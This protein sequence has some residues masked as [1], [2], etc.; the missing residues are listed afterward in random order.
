MSKRVSIV[1]INYNQTRVTC[2]LLQSLRNLTYKDVEV[3]LVDNYS[4]EDPSLEITTSFPEVKYLRSEVNLGFAGGNNLG[5]KN[6][7]GD[8]IMFLN[9]DTE[10]DPSFLEPLVELFE[11]NPDAGLASSKILYFNSGG[12]IQYAG[13]T[14]INP[15][16]GRNKRIGFMEKDNGQYNTICETDLGH[17]AAMMVPRK[18]IEKIGVMPEFF[19]LYYEEVDWCE[20]IKRAGYKIY[21]VPQSQVYH[22]ESMSVGKNSTLKTYY[23]TRNRLLFMR[24]NTTGYVK[25]F[26]IVFFIMISLPKNTLQFIV[27]REINHGKAFWKAL[28]WNVTHLSNGRKMKLFVR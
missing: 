23:L 8:Y 6:S 21:F 17:G 10:V 7:T 2:E 27:N 13:S 26:W 4:P 28:L 15:F 25:V 14:C 12:V 19:F 3:I 1:S 5:I 20:S 24:R 18:V 11:T 16:T 22:K 9:N